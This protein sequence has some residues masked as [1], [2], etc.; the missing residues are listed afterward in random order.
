LQYG[1]LT[2]GIIGVF[3]YKN[4][5]ATS[6]GKSNYLAAFDV[7]LIPFALAVFL[8]KTSRHLKSLIIIALALMTTALILSLSRGGLIACFV[9]V[10]IVLARFLSLRTFLPI[11]AMAFAIGLVVFLN[12]LTFVLIERT[13][14]LEQSASVYSRLD[15]WKE[16]WQIF[17]AHPITG[18]GL[19]NLGYYAAFVT[20]GYSSAH[21]IALGLL[22]EMGIVG[23]MLFV[24]LMAGTFRAFAQ[25]LKIAQSDFEKHLVWGAFCSLIGALL[26]SLLEPNFEGVQFSV[27]VWTIIGLVAKLPRLAS[28]PTASRIGA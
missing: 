3:L 28:E 1:G 16:T 7:L 9:A 18:V 23:F 14:T 21:N 13:A 11:I 25:S 5:M 4:L 15:F 27:M 12:P 6:W 10:L 17:Q 19:G 22:A 24:F 20:A 2:M 26:H 8:T